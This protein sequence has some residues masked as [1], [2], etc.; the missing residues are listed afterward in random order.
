MQTEKNFNQLNEL[1]SFA[2]RHDFGK[3]NN[4]SEHEIKTFEAI[5][6]VAKKVNVKCFEV[7]H[8]KQCEYHDNLVIVTL[9]SKMNEKR[10]K[11]AKR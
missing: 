7:L 9:Q 2:I 1:C 5:S 11:K 4:I 8:K 6:S 3:Y 10:N